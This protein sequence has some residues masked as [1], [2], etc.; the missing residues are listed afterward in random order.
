IRSIPGIRLG[1]SAATVRNLVGPATQTAAGTGSTRIDTHD[2]N[3][4]V[5]LTYVYDPSNRVQQSEVRVTRAVD[6]LMI[7][8]ALNGMVN[9]QLTRDLEQGLT[10]VRQGQVSQYD[11]QGDGLQ[12][13]VQWEGDR[14]HIQVWATP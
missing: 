14:L 12:G 4:R 1:T 11:F 2:L 5:R 10:Q 8:V 6:P 9:G 3:Q 13:R 7:R